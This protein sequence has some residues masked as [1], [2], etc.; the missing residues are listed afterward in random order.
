MTINKNN[1]DKVR[2]K[3]EQYYSGINDPRPDLQAGAGEYEDVPTPPDK[4]F[5][6]S[7]SLE[8]IEETIPEPVIKTKKGKN[9]LRD[10]VDPEDTKIKDIEMF[11]KK[12]NE[13]KDWENDI[14]DLDRS[15][16]EETVNDLDEN[17]LFE[18][19]D[20]DENDM[21]KIAQDNMGEQNPES[22]VD[23]NIDPNQQNPD[24]NAMM[25]GMG[26]DQNGMMGGGFG[27]EP[28]LSAENVGKVFELKKIYSRLLSIESQL[29]FSSDTILL[30]LRKFISKGIEL[31]ETVISNI[32]SYRNEID[33]IIIMYYDF[34]KEVYQIMKKYYLIQKK[35]DKKKEKENK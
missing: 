17:M 19:E 33:N 32:D 29:S 6:T 23:P 20:E 25:G 1:L 13:I 16:E 5:K 31:F 28:A 9:V 30:K 12:G 27:Q 15:E 4:E 14:E 10:P 2:T 21:G 7:I 34:L 35:E 8:D 3:L 11:D 18:Q 22:G 24:P 26:Q